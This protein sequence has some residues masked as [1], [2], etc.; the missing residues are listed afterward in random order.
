MTDP[1]NVVATP[2]GDADKQKTAEEEQIDEM[3]AD[4]R[5][6]LTS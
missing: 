5:S 2:S 4:W 1:L 6:I 3:K